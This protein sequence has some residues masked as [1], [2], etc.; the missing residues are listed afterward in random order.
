MQRQPEAY[1]YVIKWLAR[2]F[3]KPNERG[4]TVIVLRS[5]EGTGKNIIIDIL[6]NALGEHVAVA[7]KPDDLTGRF[8]DHLGTSVLVFANEA[9]WGGAKDQEGILKSLITDEE[10]PVERKYL[11]KYRVRNCCHLIM[12]SN[13]D[14]VAPVGMDDRRFVILDV[15]EARK[16]DIAYFEELVAQSTAAGEA[17]LDYLLNLDISAFNPRVLPDLGI[18]QATKRDAKI[19]GA[20]SVTQWWVHCLEMG[21]ISLA[22]AMNTGYGGWVISS[23]AQGSGNLA[24]WLG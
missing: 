10:L 15:N 24:A 3:Q 4:H 5:G 14:W 19:R 12:A 22:G 23:S 20:D 8:N 17:F 11:P 9:V 21:E 13:N 2:M 1:D 18:H 7:V 16:G 6:V